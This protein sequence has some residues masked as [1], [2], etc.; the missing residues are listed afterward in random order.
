MATYIKALEKNVCFDPIHGNG[1]QEFRASCL[2]SKFKTRGYKIVKF[3]NVELYKEMINGNYITESK[4]SYKPP[5][6]SLF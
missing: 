5:V 6:G 4:E 3:N 2:V 1:W